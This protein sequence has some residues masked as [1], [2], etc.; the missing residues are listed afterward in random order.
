MTKFKL[1]VVFGGGDVE[2]TEEW[3]GCE[4]AQPEYRIGGITITMPRGVPLERVTP[5]LPL[6]FT[7]EEAGPFWGNRDDGTAV[8][9]VDG[10]IWSSEDLA[11]LGSAPVPMVAGPAPWDRVDLPWKG[12]TED[13]D[14]IDVR[15]ETAPNGTIHAVL[16]M[17]VDQS[18]CTVP[19]HGRIQVWA[20]VSAEDVARALWTAKGEV[21][22]QEALR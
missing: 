20:Y 18:T 5:R 17:E 4:G 1:P 3:S 12:F 15:V 22:V 11:G 13:D 19:S 9:L 10:K 16:Q 21:E 2:A 8:N 14:V 7:I 6:I